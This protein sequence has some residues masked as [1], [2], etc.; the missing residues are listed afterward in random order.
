[1]NWDFLFVIDSTH[2][3]FFGETISLP[4]NYPLVV[5]YIFDGIVAMTIG[6]GISTFLIWCWGRFNQ[7]IAGG[8]ESGSDAP[9]SPS[10]PLIAPKTTSS[11]ERPEQLLI[12]AENEIEN[13]ALKVP[14]SKVLQDDLNSL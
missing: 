10:L 6:F 3:R 13:E 14:D 5:L 12:E 11:G 9:N 7:R 4:Y 1:M 2:L 8:S